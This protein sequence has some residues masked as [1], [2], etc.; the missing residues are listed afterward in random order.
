MQK[1]IENSITVLRADNG[2][3]L[4][5]GDS[6]GSV[7][8]LGVH[9]SVDNWCE[10]TEAEAEWLMAETEDDDDLTDSEVLSIILGG[11]SV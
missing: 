5:N 8:R 9:D 6:F 1:T 10:I 3:K 4:T 2:M 7:V 11:H